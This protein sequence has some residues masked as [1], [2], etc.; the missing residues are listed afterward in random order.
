MLADYEI[1]CVLLKIE[2]LEIQDDDL[3]SIAKVS[4]RDAVEKCGLPIIVED[5]GLFIEALNGFPGP[6][7]SYIH[8][9]VGNK[10]ILKLMETVE[11]RDS[12]FHSVVAFCSSSDQ[13]KC[14]HG[15]VMGRISR[16]ERGSLGFG[17]DPIFQPQGGGGKTFAEMTTVRKNKCSHRARALRGFAR[18]YTSNLE[19]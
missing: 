14:F 8:R 15:R 16:E 12:Y 18:W 13:P 3:E 2:A 9:T 10:G 17:F 6:Y 1:A 7:S 11:E 19:P 5:T 4:A